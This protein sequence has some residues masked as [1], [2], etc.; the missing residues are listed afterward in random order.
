MLKNVIKCQ[1]FDIKHF[2]VIIYIYIYIKNV[3]SD[4]T[5]LENFINLHKGKLFC[6]HF[7]LQTTQID[8]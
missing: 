3:K 5:K 8:N 4:Q 6:H 1:S 2:N 7:T